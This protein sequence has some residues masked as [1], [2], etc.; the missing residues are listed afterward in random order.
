MPAARMVAGF[1]AVT[2]AE[3]KAFPMSW[4]GT[5][6]SRVLTKFQPKR[7]ELRLEKTDFGQKKEPNGSAK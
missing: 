5:E 1:F 6:R 2:G 3:N 4:T 7:L